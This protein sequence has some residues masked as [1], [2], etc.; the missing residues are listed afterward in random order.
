[1]DV[2]AQLDQLLLPRIHALLDDPDHILIEDR[3]WVHCAF[4]G[5]RWVSTTEERIMAEI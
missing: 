5:G 1:M 4:H 2:P 3:L